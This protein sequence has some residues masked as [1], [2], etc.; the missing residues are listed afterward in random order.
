MFASS[1]SAEETSQ[2]LRAKL[3]L[4]SLRLWTR[5]RGTISLSLN[6]KRAVNELRSARRPSKRGTRLSMQHTFFFFFP[7]RLRFLNFVQI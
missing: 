1:Q 3:V 2:P 5:M 6:D 4:V 7:E